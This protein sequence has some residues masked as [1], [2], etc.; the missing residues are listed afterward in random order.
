MAIEHWKNEQIELQSFLAVG[1]GHLWLFPLN[2]SSGRHVPSDGVVSCR[3]RVFLHAAV[4]LW[5]Q[6]QSSNDS[7]L[8]SSAV[9]PSAQ[10][11]SAFRPLPFLL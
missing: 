7:E 6:S 5:K 1:Q 11:D 3:P 10:S 2:E 8:L 4:W 9:A